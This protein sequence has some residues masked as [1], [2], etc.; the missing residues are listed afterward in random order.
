[1]INYFKKHE[2]KCIEVIGSGIIQRWYQKSRCGIQDT[3]IKVRVPCGGC[4]REV[5]NGTTHGAVPWADEMPVGSSGA[6]CG[7]Q[8]ETRRSG[9]HKDA[10]G[11]AGDG[12]GGHHSVGT[13]GTIQRGWNPCLVWYWRFGKRVVV[14]VFLN[15]ERMKRN[16]SQRVWPYIGSA[17]DTLSGWEVIEFLHSLCSL[18]CEHPHDFLEIVMRV[19]WSYFVLAKLPNGRKTSI[20]SKLACWFQVGKFSECFF[21]LTFIETLLTIAKRRKHARCSSTDRDINTYTYACAHTH[22]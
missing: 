16:W 15:W 12:S 10:Q 8:T 4:E 3:R 17:I 7:L 6:R 18:Q 19:E 21:F 14:P 13:K 2:I 9:E 5:L 22:T 1:M 11:D 20:K